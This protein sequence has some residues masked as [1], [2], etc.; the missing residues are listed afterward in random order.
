MAQ[1]VSDVSLLHFTLIKKKIID[2]NETFLIRDKYCP[3]TA[4]LHLMEPNRTLPFKC[5]WFKSQPEEERISPCPTWPRKDLALSDPGYEPTTLFSLTHFRQ[6]THCMY[7]F[8]SMPS[9]Q[10]G[11]QVFYSIFMSTPAW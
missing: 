7:S 3:L 2:E 4:C 5:P 11:L 10:G 8:I 1:R 6:S 9:T